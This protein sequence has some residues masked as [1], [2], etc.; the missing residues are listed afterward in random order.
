MMGKKMSV[1]NR[2]VVKEGETDAQN[3]R[4]KRLERG[5]K[6]RKSVSEKQ[7]G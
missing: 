2:R 1:K 5:E 4:I 3:K 7:K 6:Q